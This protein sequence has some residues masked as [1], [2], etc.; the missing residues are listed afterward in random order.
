VEVGFITNPEDL[1]TMRTKKGRDGI[2]QNLFN[3]FST[4]KKRYDGPSTDE[5]PAPA[6]APAPA[7]A[8]AEA[9]TPQ[10][11]EAPATADQPSDGP[12]YGTQILAIGKEMSQ[13]DPFFKGYKPVVVKSGKL[14]KYIV[15]T[16]SSLAEAR[17]KYKAV[18]L[19]FPD[20]YLVKIADGATTPVR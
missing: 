19:K 17:K 13:T 18:Q 20:A 8:P 4:F 15:E 3:A 7:T 12:V 10:T 14:Y 5:T 2:A 6:P 11:T 1:A 9:E 16:S